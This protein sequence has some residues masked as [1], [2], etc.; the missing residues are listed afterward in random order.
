MSPSGTHSTAAA[1]V[2]SQAARWVGRA[3]S[4]SFSS[5]IRWTISVFVRLFLL[6]EPGTDLL[7]VRLELGPGRGDRLLALF[8]LPGADRGDLGLA[9][10]QVGR[11]RG[12]IRVDDRDR[13]QT[14]AP[15]RPRS[16]AG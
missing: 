11:Q 1:G 5:L 12:L 7:L 16:P 15:P 13:F 6:G 3:P 2:F 14:G 4:Y 9:F 10:R 8:L